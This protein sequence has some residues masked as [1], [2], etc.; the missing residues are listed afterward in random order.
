MHSFRY[1]A[2]QE[3]TYYLVN[4]IRYQ[5]MTEPRATLTPYLMISAIPVS[6]TAKGLISVFIELNTFII[7]FRPRYAHDIT[8]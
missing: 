8:H 3:N 2:L 5:S 1:A 4:I 6:F 7:D